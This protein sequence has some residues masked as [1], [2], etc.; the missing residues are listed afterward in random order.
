MK[1]S[2]SPTEADQGTKTCFSPFCYSVMRAEHR[3]EK[4][5]GQANV[6]A[7]KLQSYREVPHYVIESNLFQQLSINRYVTKTSEQLVFYDSLS[8]VT[9]IRS[10]EE[11]TNLKNKRS[12]DR[13]LIKNTFN[14]L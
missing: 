7:N 14:D 1:L 10:S 12:Q 6:N 2:A 8:T 11:E 3:R 9:R 13:Q 4:K 5:K